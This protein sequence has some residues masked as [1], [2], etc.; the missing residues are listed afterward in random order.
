MSD[1]RWLV[2]EGLDERSDIKPDLTNGRDHEV[3][4]E[5]RAP[6]S[7]VG[8]SGVANLPVV[9]QVFCA[10]KLRLLGFFSRV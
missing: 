6:A 9:V 1:D 7:L 5:Q 4:V 3:A 8:I 10:F 2:L